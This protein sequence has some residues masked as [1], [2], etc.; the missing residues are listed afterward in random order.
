MRDPLDE[1]TR[2]RFREMVHRL[3]QVHDLLPDVGR[4]QALQNF[5]DPL[6]LAT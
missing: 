4:L 6:L 1:V 2:S 5:P 3:P